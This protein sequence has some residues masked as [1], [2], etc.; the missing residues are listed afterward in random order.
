MTFDLLS[1]LRL[2]ALGIVAITII[3]ILGSVSSRKLN[4]KYVYGAPVSLF[5]YCLIGYKGHHTTTLPW[6]LLIVCLVGIYD[7]TVG[8]WLSVVLKANFADR[9]ERAKSVSRL[10]RIVSMMLISG[11]F[12][13]IGF[14]IAGVLR[15]T[16]T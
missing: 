3:D 16:R 1:S 9:E 7:G 8:W 15:I 6:T 14:F 13:L 5:V 2:L 11:F 4:Y 10:S 12:G